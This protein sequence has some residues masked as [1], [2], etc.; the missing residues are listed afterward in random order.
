MALQPEL[1]AAPTA[2]S[3]RNPYMLKRL[4]G[5]TGLL[6]VLILLGLGL[7]GAQ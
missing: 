3:S 1:R 2:D 4:A 7:A 6:V 5:F